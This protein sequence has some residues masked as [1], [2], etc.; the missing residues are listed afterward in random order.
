M[1]KCL[2]PL[3][4]SGNMPALS[5]R[6]QCHVKYKSE[7]PSYNAL[8]FLA[9][10]MGLLTFLQLITVPGSGPP[11]VQCRRIQLT[12]FRMPMA[13]HAKPLLT[14]YGGAMQMVKSMGDKLEYRISAMDQVKTRQCYI[15][16]LKVGA[17]LS[18]SPCP[19]LSIVKVLLANIN[20]LMA[21][22]ATELQ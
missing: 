17:V 13:L 8:L 5:M 22:T 16:K 4:P 20:V 7:P 2:I 18:V 3:I 19:L 9:S 1:Y 21:P 6:M 11:S 15:L 12:I 10:F 14:S